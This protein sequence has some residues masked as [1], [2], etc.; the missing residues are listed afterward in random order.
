[1]MGLAGAG[2]G[3]AG[4]AGGVTAITKALLTHV[5]LAVAPVVMGV[6]VALLGSE[7]R[8]MAITA[9]AGGPPFHVRVVVAPGVTGSE[10]KGTMTAFE[11]EGDRLIRGGG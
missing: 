9:R 3:G 6:G 4:V 2:G 7:P 10:T 1:M 11:R 8:G 5:T